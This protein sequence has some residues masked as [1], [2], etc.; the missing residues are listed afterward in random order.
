[1]MPDQTAQAAIDLNSKLMMPIHWGSFVL[2]LQSWNDRYKGQKK[3]NELNMLILIP[4]IG[5]QVYINNSEIEDNNW[6]AGLK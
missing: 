1:M 3:A 6:W 4:R 5:D 2:A